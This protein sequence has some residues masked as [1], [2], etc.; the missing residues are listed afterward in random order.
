[1]EDLS[2]L[3]APVVGGGESLQSTTGEVNLYYDPKS[4]GTVSPRLYIDCEGLEGTKPVAAAHQKNWQD[5]ARGHQIRQRE[6]IRI[7][8]KL[9][10]GKLY[11]K[12]VYIFSDVV[13]YVTRNPRGWSEIVNNLLEWATVAAQHAVNQYALPA[14][15]L[16]LN[17]PPTGKPS[18]MSDDQNVLT[19]EFF[20]VV[21]ADMTENA[22][23]KDL[24][25]QVFIHPLFVY[26][27][28]RFLQYGA[29]SVQ[30]IFRRCFSSVHVIYIPLKGF[31]PLGTDENLFKQYGRLLNRIKCDV[32]RVQAAREES[33][34]RFDVKQLSLAFHYAFKH[35]TSQ[36]EKPFDFGD[37]RSQT[38]L[39]KT[40][41]GHVTEFLKCSLGEGIESNFDSASLTLGSCMVMKA[42]RENGEGMSFPKF[43][44]GRTTSNRVDQRYSIIPTQYTAP[45]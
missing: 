26:R 16:V 42:L 45:R 2:S 25:E 39:P 27:T 4:F 38:D 28:L 15:I 1:M 11:P 32:E 31:P 21:E 34:R 40:A 33:W 20:K 41:K 5:G 35:L 9:A 36:S 18:W 19:N 23:V 12:F 6:G 43:F 29:E 30:E 7:D 8:R 17:G 24:A 10:V 13:C 22:F 44:S 3:D 14:A 37:C